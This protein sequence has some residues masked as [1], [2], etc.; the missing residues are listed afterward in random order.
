[1]EKGGRGENGG[2]GRRFRKMKNADFC[3]CCW[4]YFD[5]YFRLSFVHEMEKICQEFT[6]EFKGKSRDNDWRFVK[7]GTR[8]L[9]DGEG[10]QRAR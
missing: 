5:D 3:S 8:K 9:E 7:Y 2:R 10:R 4:L 6:E 1:M